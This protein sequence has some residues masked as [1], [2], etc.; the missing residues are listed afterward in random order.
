MQSKGLLPGGLILLCIWCLLLPIPSWPQAVSPQ[1]RIVQR[2]DEG[3][4]VTLRGNT[5]PLAQAQYDR[6]VAPPD[7]PMERMLLLLN[8][9]PEQ[10]SALQKLLDDQQDK[11]SPSYHHWLTPD[12]FGQ[13]FGPSDQDI[14]AVTTWLQSHGFR[15]GRVA[16]GRTVIEFSGTASEVQ[17]AFRT[18]IHKYA[19]NGEEH[20][21]NASDPQI[22]EAFAPVVAG[23][24]SLHNFPKQPTHRIAG[25][26]PTSILTGRG[27]DRLDPNYTISNSSQCGESGGYCYF[28]GPYD[29]ATIYNVLP[30]WNGTP[31]IDGTGQSI[32]IVGDS[33]I[34]IQDVR[35][36]RNLFG[37]PVNDPKI[38]LD[39]PDPGVVPGEETEAD[40]DV[41]WAGAIAKGATIKLVPSASTNSSAGIDLSAL[42]I[43]ENNLAPIVSESFGECEFFLGTAGNSY[44]SSIR[45]QAAAQGITFINSSGDEGSARCDPLSGNPPMS[46]THG[47]AVSG[48]ASSPY[49]VALGG[50]DFANFGT[51]FNYGVP[52]PY[53]SMTNNPN[54]ASALGY[55]PETT[56]NSTCTNDV[57][58]ILGY[59]STAEA[60]CNDSQAINWVETV[61]GGG[62]K[63]NCITSDGASTLSCQGGYAKPSWQSTP[64]VPA[65]GA[66]DLPD[67]SLFASSGFTD[68]AYVICESDQ[69]S[70]PC[71]LGSTSQFL[72]VGGTSVSAPAFA[73]IVAMVNQYMESTGQGNA[74]YVLYKLASLP[75]QAGLNC[76]SSDSPVSDCIFN[77]VTTGTIAVPCAR[78]SPNCDFANGSDTYGI[79]SGYNAG[80]GYDLATGL[81]SL[82][83]YNLVHD[84]N[85]ATFISTTT[86]LT[87]NGGSSVNITHGQ[88]V[89]VTIQV[90]S[91]A[92]TPTGPVSL[93]ATSGTRQGVD[94][95]TLLNGSVSSSTNQL[96]GGSYNVVA[97]YSGDGKFGGSISSPPVEVSVLPENSTT[98]ASVLT[99]VPSGDSYTF[100]PFSS[101]PY[102]SL[103]YLTA[104]VSGIVSAGHVAATG[105]VSLTD[106]GIQ[107]PGGS[108]SCPFPLNSVSSTEVPGGLMT[109]TPG[110][111]SLT[112]AYGGDASFN[113]S[114][115]TA[116]VDFIITKALTQTIL[117]S[118]P[119]VSSVGQSFQLGT[120][121]ITT[122]GF[123]PITG[124]YGGAALPTGTITLYAGTTPVGSPIPVGGTINSQTQVAEGQVVTQFPVSQLPIGQ[125]SISVVYSGDL[126]YAGSASSSTSMLVG[127]P[128]NFAVTSSNAQPLLGENVVITTQVTSTQFGGPPITGSVQF[129]V[130]GNNVGSPVSLSNGQAIYSTTSLAVGYHLIGALYSG[131]SGYL[132]AEGETNV[133]VLGPDFS[134]IPSS[135]SLVMI[136]APGASSAPITLTVSGING[137]NATI[138]FTPSS[139]T[140]PVG[141]ETSCSF[142]PTSITGSGTTQVTITTTAPHA[143]SM[144]SFRRRGDPNRLLMIGMVAASIFLLVVSEARR[145]QWSLVLG[146]IIVLAI[147]SLATSCGGG[148]STGGG[149]GSTGGG[150]VTSD[151][152]TPTNNQYTV[153][154]T[155]TATSIQTT[156]TTTLTFIVQ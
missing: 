140:F 51:N 132:S 143:L 155:A 151:P 88:S 106:N 25:V 55:I 61:A 18:E 1:S 92:G 71:N 12:A 137:Y 146:M 60:S 117:E 16:R 49:G 126:N 104:D 7:L 127:Y 46:A 133:T 156:H 43:I 26:F 123:N 101:G 149:G 102:G 103:I 19:V 130:D 124:K 150:G 44:E 87:L 91:G 109:L 118:L 121:I 73:G 24:N 59:G 68:S 136:S 15:I 52:S 98:T 22:P 105:C 142:N 147:T 128:V 14:Q 13:Q 114:T 67:I 3:V 138:N 82:N 66:R 36:F 58:V 57:F 42:Y 54:Q 39:G 93:I 110:S 141:I 122:A 125:D 50:T 64:G 97:Q 119:D 35:D 48:L 72:G 95:F 53:W 116:P 76:N 108:S 5:H 144:I 28:V 27:T 17:Q 129:S 32:A 81:G 62:G 33:N 30:L 70:S 148:G 20:W 83:A 111:H 74:N 4:R 29:F 120:D 21:A 10:E 96:P 115:T 40:L 63:S 100:S 41:E 37:L 8:R 78:N 145:R 153:T 34:N 112:A 69:T 84:W 31:T 99:V 152:G 113:P 75:S 65:D 94:D 134:I 131:G 45:E 9:S 139:C 56:W 79:L 11:L 47:L 89:P 107:I 23:V 135:V 6:G 86:N 77:D 2:V 85:L 38:I 90:T 154:V 80:A